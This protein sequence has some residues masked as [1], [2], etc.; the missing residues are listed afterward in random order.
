MIIGSDLG[1]I[2]IGGDDG[3][4]ARDFAAHEVRRHECGQRRA[5]ALA[6]GQ[7]RFRLLGRALA[8][9]ILAMGDI[10]HLRA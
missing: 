7:P 8:A 9:D 3:A 10:D 5:E 4:A 1:V 2:D 6:V